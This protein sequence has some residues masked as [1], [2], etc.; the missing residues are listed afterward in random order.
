[1]SFYVILQSNANTLTQQR[2]SASKFINDW[3]SPITLDVEYEVAVTNISFTTNFQLANKFLIST[4]RKRKDTGEIQFISDAKRGIVTNQSHSGII[5]TFEK[6]ETVTLVSK[7]AFTIEID[8]I[9]DAK[10][11][12]LSKKSVS[13]KFIVYNHSITFDRDISRKF[14]QIEVMVNFEEI[15]EEVNIYEIYDFD[16]ME[17]EKKIEKYFKQFFSFIFKEFYIDQNGYVTF[18]LQDSFEYIILDIYL[19]NALGFDGKLYFWYWNGQV[20]KAKHKMILPNLNA[21][22]Y[23]C[24]NLVEKTVVGDLILPVIAST[25]LSYNAFIN[26]DFKQPKYF[27]VKQ[28]S[29]NNIEINIV[30]QKGEIINVSDLNKTSCTLHFQPK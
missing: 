4:V 5:A 12:G 3:I 10:L 15:I 30:D 26:E 23:I 29:I 28:S 20:Y 11:L 21:K 2:N 27:P 1:M 13:S 25:F 22:I 8:T 14:K 16:F 6:G 17:N 9:K 18:L 7:K 19:S 24:T